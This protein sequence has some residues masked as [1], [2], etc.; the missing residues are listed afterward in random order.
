MVLHAEN[1][2]YTFLFIYINTPTLNKFHPSLIYKRISIAQHMNNLQTLAK[3]FDQH[4]PFIVCTDK[5][6]ITEKINI[7]K[8]DVCSVLK[9]FCNT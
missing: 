7:E 5:S 4:P 3:L 6:S 8:T 9:I 2:L 1:L